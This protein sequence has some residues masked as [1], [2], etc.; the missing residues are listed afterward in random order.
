MKRSP[1]PVLLTAA[2]GLL[3]LYSLIMLPG[4]WTD[5]GVW[6]LLFL[7]LPPLLVGIFYKRA[8][9]F[10]SKGFGKAVVWILAA[11][12]TLFFVTFAVFVGSVVR[13]SA[14]TPDPEADA[15]I[16]L[17]AGLWGGEPSPAL[18]HRLTAGLA[19]AE[20]NP[21]TLVVVSG[22]QGPDEPRSEAA[23]MAEWLTARGIDPERLVLE[24]RSYSTYENFAYTKALLDQRF[25]AGY[26]VVF[27][28]NK[29]HLPRS[30]GLA[31]DAGLDAQGIGIGDNPVFIP[32]YYTR[33]YLVQVK[34]TL[35]GADS[36]PWLSKLF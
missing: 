36:M 13:Y 3:C 16:V 26:R 34:Y 17:G 19:Y 5:L 15:V 20:E 22:G 18:Q 24:D 21:D 32:I 11:G 23:V 7:S 31:R 6:L 33:E 14:D 28:T 4:R 9:R 27:V 35:F 12:Y 30:M 29:F 2:G 10:F 8:L 1:F 25:D